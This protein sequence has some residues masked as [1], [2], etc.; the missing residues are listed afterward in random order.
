LRYVCPSG[1]RGPPSRRGRTQSEEQPDAGALGSSPLP[2]A[3]PQLSWRDRRGPLSQRRRIRVR[4]HSARWLGHEL[5]GPLVVPGE[6]PD[7]F[8]LVDEVL[9]PILGRET[10]CRIQLVPTADREIDRPF[11]APRRRI[12]ADDSFRVTDELTSLR[13]R[14][15]RD[16][17]ARIDQTLDLGLL[18]H[19]GRLGVVQVNVQRIPRGVVGEELVDHRLERESVGDDVHLARVRQVVEEFGLSLSS[20]SGQ[21][22]A[23]DRRGD[24]KVHAGRETARSMNVSNSTGPGPRGTHWTYP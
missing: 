12:E 15:N 24:L 8:E 21:E 17:D 14:A 19:A 4:P 22:K 2:A 20:V 9:R 5:K 1:P 10:H 11:P 23:R 7:P 18:G 6:L 3:V 13:A 16:L